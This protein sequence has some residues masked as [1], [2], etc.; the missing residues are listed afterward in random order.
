V[1][2][3]VLPFCGDRPDGLELYV[4][5]KPRASRDEVLGCEKDASGQ[6]FLSVRVRAL[7]EDGAANEALIAVLAQFLDVP[8]RD[9]KLVRGAQARQ[10]TVLYSGF[11]RADVLLRLQEI[12]P[13]QAL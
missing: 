10:K 3:F 8:R 4:H 13:L 11:A 5:L 1:S 7:P 12:T 9:L 2:A 6:S